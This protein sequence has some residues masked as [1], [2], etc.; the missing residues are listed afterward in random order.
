MQ[1]SLEHSHI[2]GLRCMMDIVLIVFCSQNFKQT[3]AYS[4]THA[5]RVCGRILQLIDQHVRHLDSE[6]VPRIH[7]LYDVD[8]LL[9]HQA[10]PVV[11]AATQQSQD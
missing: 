2:T 5:S 4:I 11:P 3:N 1:I 10:N 8:E 9:R 6:R 7:L